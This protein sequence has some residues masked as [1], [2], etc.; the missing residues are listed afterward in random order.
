MGKLKWAKSICW[1]RKHDMTGRCRWTAMDLAI[2]Q[3]IPDFGITSVLK[4]ILFITLKKNPDSK[5]KKVQHMK[6]IKCAIFVL[7][8]PVFISLC[9]SSLLTTVSVSAMRFVLSGVNEN[10]WI[11]KSAL[12]LK[13]QL[14][15]EYLSCY[16]YC[17]TTGCFPRSVCI[18]SVTQDQAWQMFIFQY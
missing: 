7:S 1:W 14:I 12:L 17:D 18:E 16:L 11:M 4:S 15:S 3:I 6:S 5:V 2:S 8:S 9:V 10:D 13:E